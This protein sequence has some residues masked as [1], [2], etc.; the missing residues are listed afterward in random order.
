MLGYYSRLS[1]E[2]YDI[3]KPIGHSFGDIE[4]YMDRLKSV[5]G[6]ILEPATGTGRILIPL[7][8]KGFTVD[9]FD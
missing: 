1:S 5:E 4:F 7:L 8:E 6:R 2:I 9:G 3:D